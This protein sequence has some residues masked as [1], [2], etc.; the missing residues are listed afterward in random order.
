MVSL[1]THLPRRHQHPRPTEHHGVPARVQADN[2]RLRDLHGTQR[3][4][5]VEFHRT[6]STFRTSLRLDLPRG[7]VPPGVPPRGH[8]P[9]GHWHR[10]GLFRNPDAHA[11]R[12][13]LRQQRALLRLGQR[14]RGEGPQP[15]GTHALG[16]RGCRSR[17]LCHTLRRGRHRQQHT[18]QRRHPLE[19]RPLDSV[20][21]QRTTRTRTDP[22]HHGQGLSQGH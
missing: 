4:P 2:H 1:R 12:R 18:L 6:R 19:V 13:L 3:T 22:H 14:R 21:A 7:D 5:V 16:G 10:R 20:P 11:P 17:S 9:D 8:L 15:A